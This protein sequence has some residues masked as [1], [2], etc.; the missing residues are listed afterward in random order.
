M[1][2]IPFHAPRGDDSRRADDGTIAVRSSIAALNTAI[3]SMHRLW[4]A[5]PSAF[6]IELIIRW[7]ELRDRLEL[8]DLR[9]PE[10]LATLEAAQA[11]LSSL[12]DDFAAW[13]KTA[14]GHAPD[15]RSGS[16]S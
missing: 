6:G 9:A 12:N 13:R 11:Q 1:N 4:Q 14:P 16:G 15:S 8:L 7:Q 10:A 3:T 5:S 2:V